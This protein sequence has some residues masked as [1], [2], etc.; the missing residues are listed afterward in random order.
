MSNFKDSLS[1]IDSGQN[2]KVDES[3]AEL[4]GKRTIRKASMRLIPIIVLCYCIAILDRTNV[5]VAALQMNHDLGLTAS[6]FGFGAGIFF[7]MYFTLEVPSNLLMMRYGVRRWITRI[8][9][10]WGLVA[11]GMAFVKG[12]VGFYSM[13]ALL[14]AAEAGFYPAMVFY[15]AQWFPSNYRSRVLGYLN[16]AGPLTFLIGAPISGALLGI[17]GALSMRGWQWMFLIEAVPALILA[18]VVWLKLTDRPGTAGWLTD[19]ERAWLTQ[20][21]EAEE[22]KV[23]TSVRQYTV[24]QAM[25]SPRILALGFVMFNVF[26]TVYSV[27]FF[28]PQIVKGF[29][30]TNFQS[31]AVSSIPFI[32]GSLSIVF[33]GWRSDVTQERYLHTAIPILLAALGLAGAALTSDLNVKV[34]ALSIVAFGAYGCTPAFWTLPSTFMSGAAMAGAIAVINSIGA[35]GGFVGLWVMG[36]LKDATGGFESGLALVAAMDGIAVVT[37]IALWLLKPPPAGISDLG[38]SRQPAETRS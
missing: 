12:P 8:M 25:V 6:M 10:T 11:A 3:S 23:K 37:I 36:L 19:D 38:G 22:A 5:G 28:L 15:L 14:G 35:L 1:I 24:L 26:L 4:L 2:D 7:I 17:D 13:R 16:V 33:F 9:L 30:L 29:G 18:G 32:A 20:R 21:L 34:I 27:G 31:G